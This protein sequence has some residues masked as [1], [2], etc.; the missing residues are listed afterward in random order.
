[1]SGNLLGCEFQERSVTLLKC[2]K[3]ASFVV[4]VRS[5][6]H[7]YRLERRPTLEEV[8]EDSGILIRKPLENLRKVRLERGGQA[9]G[10]PH[11]IFDE[12][13]PSFD[14]TTQRPHRERSLAR[15]ARVGRGDERTARA[16]G[17]TT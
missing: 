16:V 11:A 17:M 1:V 4:R 9:V 6:Q 2:E 3:V 8:R 13:A 12:R 15:A 10:E 5:T 7:R 14:Q